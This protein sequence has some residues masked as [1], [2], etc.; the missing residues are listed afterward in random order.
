MDSTVREVLTKKSRG[1]S[2]SE[3]VHTIR[4]E[5]SVLDAARTMNEHHIG[6]LLIVEGGR[7]VG[8]LSER[9]VLTRLVEARRDPEGTR[10]ADVMTPNPVTIGPSTS[11]G[12]AMRLMTERKVRHLPVVVRDDVVGIVSIGDLVWW[13]TEAL[14]S[15]VSALHSYIH[16]PAVAPTQ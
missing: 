10:V 15:E 5:S 13:V 7:P 9:D 6:S 4:P 12:D 16:G 3:A 1:G 8:I 14:Q 11:V 2:S